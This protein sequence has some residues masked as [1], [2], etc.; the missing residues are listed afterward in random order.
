MAD[1]DL[2][3][4]K[5]IT[6]S[7]PENISGW[8]KNSTEGYYSP[9]N[10]F[11]YINGNAEL[12]ISYDFRHLITLTYDNN[13]SSKITIDIFDMGK[14]ENAFGVFSHSRE[15][16]DGFVSDKIESEYGGGLLTFWKG[17]YYISI[18]AYPETQEKKEVIK[19][20]AEKISGQIPGKSIKPALVSL[21]PTENLAP[22][23]IRYFHH[24]IWLNSH[25]YISGE[26]IL[27][28]GKDTEAVL[29]KYYPEGKNKKPVILLL[30]NYPDIKKAESAYE[31]FLTNYLPEAEKGFARLTDH[32]WAG[33][34]QNGKIISIILNAPDKKYAGA[35]LSKIK[36]Q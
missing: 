20:I 29:A 22:F 10:L 36:Y 23:S 30:I 4:L 8:G 21:L 16:E 9:E 32:R 7:L 14:P 15:Y 12:F 33:S 24:H 1:K 25:Y 11:E 28:L 13:L 19:K 26:N 27:N 18:L 2:S 35:L 31:S 17:K 5:K 34:K 3:T 6:D